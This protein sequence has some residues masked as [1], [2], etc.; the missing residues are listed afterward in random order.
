MILITFGI[1]L[2]EICTKNVFIICLVYFP[3]CSNKKKCHYGFKAYPCP[4]ILIPLAKWT[5]YASILSKK[6]FFL[7]FNAKK[8]GNTFLS[9]LPQF[10]KIGRTIAPSSLA[11]EVILVTFELQTHIEHLSSCQSGFLVVCASQSSVFWVFV[12][13]CQPL[14]ICLFVMLYLYIYIIYCY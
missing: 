12:I 5:I 10:L 14:N 1:H 11:N 8:G 13:F 3:N 7:K 9:P 2:Y 6:V 4:N